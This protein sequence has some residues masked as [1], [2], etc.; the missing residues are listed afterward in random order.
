MKEKSSFKASPRFVSGNQPTDV[1]LASKIEM[2]IQ[3]L[4]I[5]FMFPFIQGFI[6][7]KT[8]KLKRYS[9]PKPTDKKKNSLNDVTILD[10]VLIFI[11]LVF[12]VYSEILLSSLIF[13]TF[14]K[15]EPEEA[16]NMARGTTVILFVCAVLI[17]RSVKKYLQTKSKIPKPK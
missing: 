12:G 8:K 13:M 16:M 4:T 14:F 17:K 1:E 11:S 10:T 5:Q 9:I 3:Q 7:K 6:F 15:V 2:W